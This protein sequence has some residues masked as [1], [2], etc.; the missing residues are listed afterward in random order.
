MIP[1]ASSKSAEPDLEL[2]ARLPCFTTLAPAALVT[3]AAAVEIFIVFAPSPP[4]P[5]VSTE[6]SAIFIAALYEYICATKAST[7][8]ALSPFA[9]RPV[10]NCLISSLLAFPSRICDIAQV[11]CSLD[12]SDLSESDLRIKSQL[13][14]RL[15]IILR[16][17]NQF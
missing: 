4:V 5:T 2:A 9:L 12:R 3:I 11:I 8:A 15:L 17:Q 13:I 6:R 14:G 16:A 7:S 1:S 10:R